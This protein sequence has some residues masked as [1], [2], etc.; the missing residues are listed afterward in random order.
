MLSSRRY[1]FVIVYP[2][3]MDVISYYLFIELKGGQALCINLC[4]A[5]CLSQHLHVYSCIFFILMTV[6][7]TNNLIRIDF[8]NYRLNKRF[9][10]KI[11]FCRIKF[12]HI[13]QYLFFSFINQIL[14]IAIINELNNQIL[15]IH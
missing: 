2:I 5:S 11:E 7:F 3:E 8:L 6:S 15:A 14:N 1:F 10:F 4:L 13:N 9:L 12:K